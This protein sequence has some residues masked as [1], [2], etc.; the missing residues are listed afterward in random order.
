MGKVE[1][2]HFIDVVSC[3]GWQDL[4]ALDDRV[5]IGFLRHIR[6]SDTA[7]NIE[8]GLCIIPIAVHL[9]REAIDINTLTDPSDTRRDDSGSSL[10]LPCRFGDYELQCELG[11]GGM[12]VVYRAEQQSLKRTVAVKM[13]LG[14]QLAS[15]SDLARFR[16]EAEAAARL[17]HSGIV[18]VY[19]VGE[20]NGRPYFNMKYV[21]GQT[22][23]QRLAEGSRPGM[24]GDRERRHS[25]SLWIALA[26]VDRRRGRH[27][28]QPRHDARY[29]S[30]HRQ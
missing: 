29:R 1:D 30:R 2:P 8:I 23:A 20:V 27:L 22:L 13:I 10:A 14:G 12:G 5:I 21:P 11:R 26:G 19:E 9:G 3:D 6:R 7:Q 17:D 25:E 18:P 16:A 4:K 28:G 15:D 24:D